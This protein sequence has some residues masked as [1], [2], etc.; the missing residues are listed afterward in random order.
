MNNRIERL[1]LLN[2]L[3]NE[4]NKDSLKSLTRPSYPSVLIFEVMSEGLQFSRRLN[5][6]LP[7]KYLDKVLDDTELDT[8]L[9]A[10]GSGTTFLLP[11]N[12][13]GD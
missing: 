13:R 10:G 9:F 6:T 8:M 3:F 7:A 5:R 12:G 2:S 1:K 4:D 11:D